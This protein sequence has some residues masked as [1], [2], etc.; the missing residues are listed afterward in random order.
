MNKK[1]RL[2][3]LCWFRRSRSEVSFSKS[4]DIMRLEYLIFKVFWVFFGG[5]GFSR[6]VYIHIL[7]SAVAD[8]TEY[9][10]KWPIFKLTNEHNMDIAR[11]H[12]LKSTIDTWSIVILPDKALLLCS[13]NVLP[14][15]VT[16]FVPDDVLPC[17]VTAFVP[18]DVLGGLVLVGTGW[19]K[20]IPR[21]VAVKET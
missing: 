4:L 2:N 17:V 7:K 10:T 16:A 8:I 12:I 6:S 13:D 20:Q 15:V 21:Q 3:F 18:A 11:L 5:V 1:P 19:M 14:C 9:L